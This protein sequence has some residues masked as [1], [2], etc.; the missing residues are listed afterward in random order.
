MAIYE[1][2]SEEDFRTELEISLAKYRWTKTEM[3]QTRLEE[4]EKEEITDEEKELFDEIEAKCR[5]TYDPSTNNLDL[6][7]KRVTDLKENTKVHLPKPLPTHQEAITAVRREKWLEEHSKYER[8][9]C[10]ENG[11]QKSNLSAAQQRGLKKLRKRIKEGEIIVVKTDKSGKLAVVAVEDYIKMGEIHTSNDKEVDEEKSKEIQRKLNG[12]VSMWLKIT[13]I[14]EDWNHGD[15][16]RETCI[17][18]SCTISSMYLLIKDHKTVKEGELPPTRPVCSSCGSMGVHLSNILSEILDAIVNSLDGKIEVISTEDMLSKVDAYNKDVDGGKECQ[19]VQNDAKPIATP[20]C[21]LKH[22]LGKVAITGADATALYP[23]LKGR[24][25]AELARDAYLKSNLKI[26]GINYKEAAR[27]V[28]IGYDLFEIRK[29]GLERVVPKRRYKNGGKPGLTGNG[30]LGRETDDEFQWVFPDREA[31]DLEKRKL[32]AAC[33]EI[34]VRQAFALH[35][36]QFGGRVYHQRDGGPIG[37]R[38]A[39]SVARIVMA[40]WGSRF[41]KKMEENNIKVWLAACYVD[42]VRLHQGETMGCQE[43]EI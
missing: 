24:H 38:L 40:E 26:D 2:L 13:N 11:N 14:G 42:D 9:N 17:N 4:E 10:D 20:K 5:V 22:K 27:Y 39:G 8:E 7:K 36:Y 31:T 18:H 28:A 16:F 1:K 21:Q 12:N 15:R 41:M 30:P 35:L 23:N 34:G 6:R 37:M 32:F 19:V 25:S 3:N 33:L 43:K 29:M